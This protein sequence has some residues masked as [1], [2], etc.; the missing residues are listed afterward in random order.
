MKYRNYLYTLGWQIRKG[1][2]CMHFH[3]SFFV[4]SQLVW[5]LILVTTFYYSYSPLI[6]DSGNLTEMAGFGGNLFSYLV[7]GIIVIYLYLEYVNLGFRL[8]MDRDYGVLEPIFLTPVNRVFWL[9]GTALTVVPSGILASSGF[10]LSSWLFFRIPMPH[11]FLLGGAVLYVLLTSLPWGAMVCAIFIGGRNTRFLYSFFET[12][13]EFLSGARF[14]L[15][16]L[17]TW[18]STISLFYPLSHGI[19][20]LRLFWTNPLPLNDIGSEMISLT[21]LSLLY[22][23][24]AYFLFSWAEERGKKNGTLTFT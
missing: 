2:K 23:F 24:L 21:G 22:G 1:L 18:L 3:F 19:K 10:L 13:A 4:L 16:A 17:P 15:T 20:F 11:P 8:S 6:E 14:P 9:F 5:P 7:P 12:P